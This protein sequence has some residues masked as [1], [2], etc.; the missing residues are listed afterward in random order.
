V[1]PDEIF[2]L[3]WPEI[4]LAQDLIHVRRQIDLDTGKITWPKDDSSPTLARASAS[5]E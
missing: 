5:V 1:R 2:A 4:H 3:H